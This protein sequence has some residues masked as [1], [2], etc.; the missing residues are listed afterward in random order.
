MILKFYGLGINDNYQA[1]VKIY[2]NDIMIYNT[3]T[4]NGSLCVNLKPCKRYKVIATFMG[5]SIVKYIYSC[6]QNVILFFFNHSFISNIERT[7]TFTLKD[8]NYGL[9][10]EKGVLILNGKSN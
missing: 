9:L 2:D 3:F 6:S 7:I 4:Y 10:I 5:D 8:L 1:N